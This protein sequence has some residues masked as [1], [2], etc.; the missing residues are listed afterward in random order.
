MFSQDVCGAAAIALRV[1]GT[2]TNTLNKTL[3]PVA[4]VIKHTHPRNACVCVCL[5]AHTQHIQ[6]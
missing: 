3:L 1:V 5:T 4:T 2:G 6:E